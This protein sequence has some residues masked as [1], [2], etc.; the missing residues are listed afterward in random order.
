M[1]EV[2]FEVAVVIAITMIILFSC[3]QYSD[4]LIGFNPNKKN[5]KH[6]YRFVSHLDSLNGEI[7]TFWDGSGWNKRGMIRH[8]KSFLRR[9]RHHQRGWTFEIYDTKTH[10]TVWSSDEL[11]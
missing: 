5:P 3:L 9:F 8:Q 11:K 7:S 2:G 4:P 6:R 10:T 1:P